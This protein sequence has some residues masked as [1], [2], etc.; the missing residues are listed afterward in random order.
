EPA[1]FILARG[2]ATGRAGVPAAG[3][4]A[5]VTFDMARGDML[6]V[7]TVT[8]RRPVPVEDAEDS[9]APAAAAAAAAAATAAAP[10]AAPHFHSALLR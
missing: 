10:A 7:Q 3:D 2:R 6:G 8:A 5:E 4:A 1:L 9:V